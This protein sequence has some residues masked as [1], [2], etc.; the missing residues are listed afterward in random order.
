MIRAVLQDTPGSSTEPLEVGRVG[1]GAVR[2]LL[3]ECWWEGGP[4]ALG[5]DGMDAGGLGRKQSFQINN[6]PACQRTLAVTLCRCERPRSHQGMLGTRQG[7]SCS[8][9][10]ICSLAGRVAVR[11]LLHIKHRGYGRFFGTLPHVDQ[12]KHLIS[13]PRNTTVSFDPQHWVLRISPQ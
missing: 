5:G 1:K 2:R 8:S 4:C 3:E 9:P 13:D 11:G 6:K 7:D 10:L 12:W